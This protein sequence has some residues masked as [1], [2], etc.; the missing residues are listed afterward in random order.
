MNT[1]K[2]AAICL[3]GVC[4][5]LSAVEMRT[6]NGIRVDIQPVKDWFEDGQKGARPM[7][8]WKKIRVTD[9]MGSDGV[10][11]RC[12]VLIEGKAAEVQL[13]NMPR[14]ICAA[15]DSVKKLHE[16][17]KLRS[18]WNIKEAKRLKQLEAVTPVAASGSAEFVNAVMNQRAALE[19]A[20]IKLDDSIDEVEEMLAAMR[21]VTQKA[22]GQATLY[23]MDSGKK[24]GGLA[25]WDC[26]GK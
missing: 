2:L 20:K 1:K 11:F 19:R 4:L 8:H 14:E 5:N 26:G 12:K 3:A 18:E 21:S 10:W 22:M 15:F 9:L 23:A 24:Y 25:V 6:V 16:R 13:A 17:I 7:P